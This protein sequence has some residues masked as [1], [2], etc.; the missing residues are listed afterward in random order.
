MPACAPDI[1]RIKANRTQQHTNTSRHTTSKTITIKKQNTNTQ[2]NKHKQ[3]T[4]EKNLNE[5]PPSFRVNN[6]M[7]VG[8][9]KNTVTHTHTHTHSHICSLLKPPPPVPST[10]DQQ[11]LQTCVFCMHSFIRC[12]KRSPY[13]KKNLKGCRQRPQPCL[14]QK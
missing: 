10:I 8:G 14:E 7:T 1:N 11:S 3:Q 2:N 4:N 5:R 9:Y 6:S 12:S 13:P